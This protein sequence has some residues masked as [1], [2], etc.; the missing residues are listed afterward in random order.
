MRSSVLI[1][2]IFLVAALPAR[3]QII[4]TSA[5]TGGGGI[6][7]DGGPATAALLYQPYGVTLDNVGN[8]YICDNGKRQ[9][10]KVSPAYGGVITAVAGNGTVG[11]SGDGYEAIYAQISGASDVAVDKNGNVF[12]A[13]AGNHRIRVVSPGGIITTFA[14]TGV[15][16]YN[17]DGMPATAANLNGPTG[18]CIDD[19]GNVIIAEFYSRRIRK[20]D[21]FGIIK[22]V[23]GNGAAGFTTDGAKADTA[24]LNYTLLVRVDKT[25]AIY[26]ID[27][28]RIR[29]I[30]TTGQ[31]VTVVGNGIVG[32]SGDGGPATAATVGLS[33]FCID[34]SGSIFIAD[35]LNDV[36]RKIS[37]NGIIN[38]FA[39]S[40]TGG[41][42]GDGGNALAAKLNL[43]Q[44]VAVAP[45]GDVFIGDVGNNRIR[46]VS[47]HIA[48]ASQIH[49]TKPKL[50]VYPNPATDFINIELSG[51]APQEAE[52]SIRTI[53]G[54]LVGRYCMHPTAPLRLSANWPAGTYV[55]LVTTATE[56]ISKTIT[57]NAPR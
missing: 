44:G 30:S 12:I 40:G 38:R 55:V 45:N 21:T 3:S 49:A 13:D 36:I 19:T 16:G 43:C 42:S 14:G 6:S 32:N 56:N 51:V 46:M 26:F 25:G 18:I 47:N 39:G 22:T 57:I 10:R 52:V 33:A 17:G 24:S 29:K 48:G 7:G 41:Y 37:P 11:F 50:E 4:I 1:W 54:R 8:L 5:G 27:N 15:A 31:L 20:I 23:A 35:G 34:S 2:L 28:D 9:V 53:D